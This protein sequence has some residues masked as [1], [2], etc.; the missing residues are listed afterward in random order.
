MIDVNK[1]KEAATLLEKVDA[2][3]FESGLYDEDTAHSTHA[4]RDL[5]EDLDMDIARVEDGNLTDDF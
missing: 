5:I 3:L 2:L 4:L 1:M